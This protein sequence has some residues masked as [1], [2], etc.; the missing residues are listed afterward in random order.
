MKSKDFLF[1]L[2]ASLTP[3]EKRYFK[4]YASRHVRGKRNN[5][6]QLFEA[7]NRQKV[8][9]ED[10]ILRTFEGHK[11]ARYLSVAKNYLYSL[12]LKS[13]RA[14]HN[15]NI[16]DYHSKEQ[17]DFADI[18]RH[19]GLFEQAALVLKRA[20][21]EALERESHIYAVQALEQERQLLKRLPAEEYYRAA[22]ANLL[23]QQQLMEEH[24]NRMSYVRL[25]HQLDEF[26]KKNSALRTKEAREWVTTFMQHPLLRS[27][28][29][30]L[31]QRAKNYFYVIM[32]DCHQ[33]LGANEQ[34]LAYNYKVLKVREK[35]LSPPSSSQLLNYISA[36]NNYLRTCCSTWHCDAIPIYVERLR[37][38]ESDSITVTVRARERAFFY[39][40]ALNR[41]TGAYADSIA[42]LADLTRF[43]EEYFHQITPH[44]VESYYLEIAI[45]FFGVGDPRQ[46]LVWLEKVLA[47]K[48]TKRQEMVNQ[49]KLLTLIFHFEAGNV[50]VLESTLRSTYRYFIKRKHLFQFE[51]LVINFIRQLHKALS[52]HE[53]RLL[54][55]SMLRET[56]ALKQDPF[57][58]Q[59]I[60]YF[61][62][63]AW[64]ISRIENRPF[65]D[66]VSERVAAWKAQRQ[67]D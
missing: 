18:L 61:D 15:E 29:M 63:Q 51:S 50:A 31:S 25:W 14:Y 52:D 3:S 13:L 24:M 8:Y 42:G 16:Y 34:A 49:A 59:A 11:V 33:L 67:M 56:E 38:I 36:I 1:D 10:R 60:E 5:Y 48:S 12:I 9:D 28:E 57:E 2:I 26:Q 32:S 20:K 22:D 40:L 46:A 30:A 58:R 19:K 23:Q 64:L 66:V 55:E 65:S 53:L 45:A 6:V 39:E 62:V 35:E 41:M 4:V 54:F 27:E 37:S 43:L 21:K 44:Y 47:R 17:L 7:I